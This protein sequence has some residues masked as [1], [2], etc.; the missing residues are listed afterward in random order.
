MAKI[1]L[2]EDEKAMSD[3]VAVK[4]QVEGFEVVQAFTIAEAKEKFAANGPFDVVLTDFLLPD[5]ELVDFLTAA[6]PV[7]ASKHI[8]V[9]LMTNYAEDVNQQQLKTMGV[10][11]FLVKYQTVP[12]QMAEK[13]KAILSQAPQPA[14][15]A[16]N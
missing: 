3:L 13:V 16:V 15:P 9:I 8:P 12:A 11:E 2:I 10:V 14:A 4:F 5:G 6:Q 1:L 7:I